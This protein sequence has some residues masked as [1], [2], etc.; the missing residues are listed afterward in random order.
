MCLKTNFI[1]NET[2]PFISVNQKN[3]ISSYAYLYHSLFTEL[4]DYALQT[5]YKEKLRKSYP[6]HP[7]LID[8][9][10]LRW[11]SHP[12]FQRTR[13][14]LRILAAIV[15]DL[16]KRQTSLTG[17]HA[18]IHTSDVNFTNVQALTSQITILYGANW[19]SVINADIAGTTSNAFRIDNQ[20]R[21]FGDNGIT[22][23]IATTILLGT[24][25]SQGQLPAG[26]GPLS[27]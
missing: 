1:C 14:V 24:F 12:N 6:F 23:G 4:P 19:D 25:G 27:E 2:V 16:W 18:L 17:Q 20:V 15:S 8:M 26:N 10:R 7:E 5:E 21:A 13:G 9:F 3:I 22:Q 11:A